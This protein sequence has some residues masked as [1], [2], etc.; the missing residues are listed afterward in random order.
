MLAG[1]TTGIVNIVDPGID[2]CF[3]AAVLYV[4]VQFLRRKLWQWC[5]FQMFV[6]GKNGLGKLVQRDSRDFK[7]VDVFFLSSQ[8]STI[9]L[10]SPFG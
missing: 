7:Y 8:E 1:L 9:Q 6:F 3:F 10:I 2:L 5:D 4:V